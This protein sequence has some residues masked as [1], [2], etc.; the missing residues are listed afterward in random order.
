MGG[1]AAPRQSA[2]QRIVCST[3]GRP[4]NPAVTLLP[5][6]RGPGDP[7]FHIEPD[8]TIWRTS[9]LDSG[10]VTYRVRPLDP[11][12]VEVDVRGPGGPELLDTADHLLGVHDDD[13]GFA[14]DHPTLVAARRRHPH[15]RLCRTRRVLE[16][17]VPAILEQRVTGKEAFSSWRRLLTRHGDPAPGP[18]PIGMRVPPSA[19]TWR[20]LPSWEFHRA[21]VDPGRAKTIV[22]AATVADRLEKLAHRSPVEA[23]R[24]LRSLPGIGIWTAAEV[25]QRALGDPDALSVGDFHLSRVVGVALTG[26]GMTDEEM[27]AY[28]EPMRPHRYRVVRLLEL[29]GLG[30][31]SRRAPRAAITDHRGH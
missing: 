14:P 11:Y 1:T 28:L 5:L 16:T 27:V 24:A 13:S 25:A 22:R 17:L 3:D 20:A 29:T 6:R 21:G 18:A 19:D 7:T 30:W 10:A 31:E 23:R 2:A 12:R 15:V 26:V 4:L 9:R 8:G